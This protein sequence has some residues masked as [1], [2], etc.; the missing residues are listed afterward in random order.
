M[1]HKHQAGFTQLFS[2]RQGPGW[3]QA[4]I[5]KGFFEVN[6][7][8]TSRKTRDPRSSDCI[9]YLVPI[10]TVQ[11]LAGANKNIVFIPGVLN[12]RA[13]LSDPQGL[14]G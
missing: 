5:N 8:A 11:Q 7:T 6:F 14:D 13:R 2:N 1:N 3:T 4:A 9:H 12:F 10:P